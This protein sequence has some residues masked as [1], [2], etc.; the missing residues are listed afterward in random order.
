MITEIIKKLR[1]NNVTLYWIQ[2]H[3][4]IEGNAAVQ[5]VAFSHDLARLESASYDRT[6]KLWDS[7]QVHSRKRSRCRQITRMTIFGKCG[8]ANS[9]E[10]KEILSYSGFVL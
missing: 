5:S 3:L 2:G 8:E 6:V 7:L 1:M 4:G 9:V 10:E